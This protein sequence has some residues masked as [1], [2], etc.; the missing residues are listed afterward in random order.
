MKPAQW[1]DSKAHCIGLFLNGQAGP[2]ISATGVRETD[3]ALLL[4]L[5]AYYDK[6]DFVLPTL[7]TTRAWGRILDTTEPQAD[8]ASEHCPGET[9]SMP[10]RSAVV[11]VMREN[12][13]A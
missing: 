4:V 12:G 11:F 10:G 2:D 9:Y 3:V 5:N 6:V 7:P 1:Q 13:A 8:A